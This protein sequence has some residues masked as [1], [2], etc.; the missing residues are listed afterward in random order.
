MTFTLLSVVFAVVVSFAAVVS[1]YLG[2][3]SGLVK[4]AVKLAITV[5][6]AFLGAAVTVLIVGMFKDQF[7]QL[8]MNIEALESLGD[9]LSDYGETFAA[10]LCMVVSAVMFVPVFGLLYFLSKVTVSVIYKR[11]SKGARANTAEH[12]PENASF[13]DKNDTVTFERKYSRPKTGTNI[14][15]DTTIHRIAANVSP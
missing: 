5:S 9:I 8:A 12:L 10:I 15:A 6:S 7:T 13:F 2:Y 11:K 3:K 4:S 1:A 14:T